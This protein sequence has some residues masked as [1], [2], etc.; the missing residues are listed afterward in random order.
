M[1]KIKAKNIDSVGTYISDT[2][3]IILTIE[4]DEFT[5]PAEWLTERLHAENIQ[6]IARPYMK[7]LITTR[8]EA[9]K[10]ILNTIAGTNNTP[11]LYY[12]A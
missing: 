9:K 5:D 8:T 3:N 11:T 1:E 10:C 6:V 7:K 12:T 4:Y 2:A